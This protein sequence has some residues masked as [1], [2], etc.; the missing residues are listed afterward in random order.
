MHSQA[1]IA[2]LPWLRSRYDLTDYRLASS[3]LSS[4]NM[5]IQWKD[6]EAKDRLLASVIAASANVCLHSPMLISVL[7]NLLTDLA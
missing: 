4:V 5:A 3:S 2:S 7:E 6:P 1:R